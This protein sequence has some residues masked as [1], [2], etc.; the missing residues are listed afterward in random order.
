MQV[1]LKICISQSSEPPLVH[2]LHKFLSDG[3]AGGIADDGVDVA[4]RANGRGLFGRYIVG[5]LRGREDVAAGETAALLR[6]L[7]LRPVAGTGVVRQLQLGITEGFTHTRVMARRD[8]LLV[9]GS[10]LL[11]RL[12]VKLVVTET[13]HFQLMP[14]SLMG[15]RVAPLQSF[16]HAAL[17]QVAHHRAEHVLDIVLLGVERGLHIVAQLISVDMQA[18][19]AS[20][21]FVDVRFKKSATLHNLFA[22]DVVR[23]LIA[24]IT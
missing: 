14:W 2:L 20:Q 24:Y 21:V 13:R 17:R 19:M 8:T 1:S 22:T 9:I 3:I 6:L 18:A 16:S 5:D 23:V 11:S 15:I 7:Y 10:L 4:V 12:L